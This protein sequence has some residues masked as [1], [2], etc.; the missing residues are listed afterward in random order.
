MI[1]QRSTGTPMNNAEFAD[2]RMYATRLS[3]EDILDL[4][5]TA[6]KQ[7]SNGKSIPFEIIETTTGKVQVCLRTG[8]IKNDSFIESTT[9]N[10]FKAT[11]VISNEFI[12]R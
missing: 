12:E 3:D 8:V 2:F 1:G 10:K 5:H 11:Q 6:L 7:L 4:Y 9:G